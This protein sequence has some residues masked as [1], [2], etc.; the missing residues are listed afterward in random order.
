[1]GDLNFYQRFKQEIDIEQVQ[2]VFINRVTN[3]LEQFFPNLFG[4]SG[5]SSSEADHWET[6]NRGIAYYMGIEY[7]GFDFFKYSSKSNFLYFLRSIDSLHSSFRVHQN[8]SEKL[9]EMLERIIEVALD[10]SE[11]DLNVNFIN[12]KFHVSYGNS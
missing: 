1:M 7:K 12:G 4:W 8:S 11:L 6:I 2:K 10:I 9:D 5:T 3:H